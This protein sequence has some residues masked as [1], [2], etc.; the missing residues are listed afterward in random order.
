[1]MAANYQ[2]A[3]YQPAGYQP[4]GY[5]PAGYQEVAHDRGAGVRAMAA[6]SVRPYSLPSQSLPALSA[7]VPAE[8]PDEA[9]YDE[10]QYDE[11]P[12]RGGPGGPGDSTASGQPGRDRGDLRIPLLV[13][14][15]AVL[16]ATG[17][18][19]GTAIG[20]SRQS[21]TSAAS[22]ASAAA[23]PVASRSAAAVPTTSPT[24]AKAPVSA[25]ETA[26]EPV[27]DFT[28]RLNLA[29]C[30]SPSAT[31]VTCTAPDPKGAIASATFQTFPSLSALY[32]AYQ[33]EVAAMAGEPF[34]KVENTQNCGSPAPQPMGEIS[35]N[36]SDQHTLKYSV[37]QLASG[38]VPQD[39]A[40]GRMFCMQLS[41]GGE[42]IIWTQN[43]GDLLVVAH[44]AV[45]HEQVWLWFVAVHH[46]IAFKGQPAM[47]GMSMG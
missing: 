35:W 10:A 28:G 6:S 18:G 23:G 9:P 37:A 2:P 42:N 38:K 1:M 14:A 13:L 4:A 41:G 21:A 43:Y 45:S 30:K 27:Q 36:H 16:I 25:L 39:I 17:A 19:I 31:F 46:N 12:Y 7:P 44:G 26:L 8:Y 34:G 32:T 33:A 15:A 11:A 24:A 29:D 20:L 40:A 5:Q 22:A 47:T 3:G